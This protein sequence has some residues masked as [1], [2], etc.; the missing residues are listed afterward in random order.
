M[1]RNHHMTPSCPPGGGAAA[2]PGL[3]AAVRSSLRFLLLA[4]LC[5]GGNTA[6]ADGD[7]MR[8]ATAR[9]DS[10]VS[11]W[12]RYISGQQM[13]QFRGE[14]HIVTNTE[15]TLALLLDTDAMPGWLWRCDNARILNKVS[16]REYIVYLRFRAFWPLSDRDAVLRV[17]PSY[18]TKTGTLTLTGS[19]LPDYLPRMQGVVRVPAI[20]SSFVL[21]PGAK[22]MRVEMNGHFDPG[23]IIPLWA[24]NLFVTVFPKHSLTQ[25]REILEGH[26]YS[27]GPHLKAGRDALA[28]IVAAP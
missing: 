8:V 18:D 27:A 1:D 2:R 6:R 22:K 28:G 11:I 4:A 13:K 7:W 5:L 16:A 26:S 10:D 3:P 20:A 25:M 24:A 19:A 15:Q 21:Q 23:G 9:S 17:V 12:S 14:T